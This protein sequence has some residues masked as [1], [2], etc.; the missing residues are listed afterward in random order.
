[1]SNP[2]QTLE[3]A[4]QSRISRV[5]FGA[6]ELVH[7]ITLALI[8]RGHILLEGPP[9]LG[10]TLLAKTLAAQIGGEFRRIQCTADLMPSDM[11]GLHIYRQDE[12]RFEWVPGPLFADVV[13][14]DEINRTGPK[15]QSALLE[16]MEER[17]V[18]VDRESYALPDDFLVIATQNPHEFEG[19]FPLPESQ[20]DRF[21]LRAVLTHPDRDTEEKVLRAYDQPGSQVDIT[22]ADTALPDN[23]IQDAR[24][25]AAEVIVSDAVYEYAT[26]LCAASREHAQVSLGLSTRGALALMRTARAEAALNGQHYVTPDH[27]KELA[28]PVMSHRLLL[29]PEAMLEDTQTQDVVEAI[30]AAVPVP[31]GETDTAVITEAA[32]TE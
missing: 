2:A 31:R 20:L 17:R 19:T 10:K 32:S 21:L 26:A 8:A 11:T 6:N 5:I 3:Q 1:M 13:L 15:T 18:T 24:Q 7:Q 22:M 30:L 25:N 12:Q 23:L 16:A 14:V 27:L 29:T 4:L 28:G 9:G